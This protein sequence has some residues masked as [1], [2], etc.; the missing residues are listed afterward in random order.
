MPRLL[1]RLST[2]SSSAMKSSPTYAT[3]ATS[4]STPHITSIS[5]RSARSS[6]APLLQLVK[7]RDELG[8]VLAHEAGHMVLHHVAKRI[9]NAETVG[10]IGGIA[11]IFAALILGPLAGAGAQYALGTAM[12]AQDAN[13]SRHVEA[14]ADEEG[15]RI[16]AATGVL[17]PYGM[18]WFFEI[19]K[20]KYGDKGAFWQRD[21][22][23]DDARITDLRHLFAADSQVFGKFTDTEAKDEVYW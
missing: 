18:I 8:G 20:E 15:A 12:Q 19:L 21:H 4:S 22:P 7:N 3:A 16:A 23:F 11:G 10:T 5:T 2:K 1:Q 17:N 14:Q 9:R 13:L 6:R